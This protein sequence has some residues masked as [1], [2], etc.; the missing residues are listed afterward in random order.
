[1][2]VLPARRYHRRTA[3]A[4]PRKARETKAS[5][6]MDRT[7]RVN[8][9]DLHARIKHAWDPEGILNPGKALPRW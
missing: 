2:T 3:A 4:L 9:I 1:M 5:C 6:T 7:F 8:G